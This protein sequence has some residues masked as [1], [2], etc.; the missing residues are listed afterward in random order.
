MIGRPVL[1]NMP[2]TVVHGRLG[3]V[4]EKV[5]AKRGHRAIW[6]VELLPFDRDTD[7]AG[8]DLVLELNLNSSE[9]RE[10]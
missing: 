5:V 2:G 4:V 3:R 10:A 9:F 6:K 1:I 8:E 7:S